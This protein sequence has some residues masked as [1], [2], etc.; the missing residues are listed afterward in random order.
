MRL[1]AFLVFISI[2][3]IGIFNNLPSSAL[4]PTDPTSEKYLLDHGHSKEIVRMINLQKD[5]T[6]G[7]AVVAPK[8][9]GKIKKFFKNL[10]YEQ[11]VSMPVTDFGFNE[12]KSPETA[13]DINLPKNVKWPTLKRKAENQEQEDNDN[14]I[15]ID[16]VKVRESL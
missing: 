8:S 16:E 13:K 14:I 3:S 2:I 1:K 7:K 4:S 6:E 15:I 12:I 11:D 10:W 5:R 9:Q